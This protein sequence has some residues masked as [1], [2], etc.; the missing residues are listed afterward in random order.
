[1]DL[2]ERS[3]RLKSIITSS[4]QAYISA[5][6][7]QRFSSSSQDFLLRARINLPDLSS[8]VMQIKVIDSR[9]GWIYLAFAFLP[10]LFYSVM[11]FLE[12]A[13]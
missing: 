10:N 11:L 3:Q 2:V 7:F 4:D 8:S 13:P 9:I 1:M 6:K 5:Q 12:E